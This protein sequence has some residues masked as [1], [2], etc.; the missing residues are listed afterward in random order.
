MLASLL[1]AI[2]GPVSCNEME[3]E[4]ESWRAVTTLMIRRFVV[5]AIASM[6][7]WTRLRMTS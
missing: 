2:P 4:W 6:E 7:F 3:I 5:V 1:G